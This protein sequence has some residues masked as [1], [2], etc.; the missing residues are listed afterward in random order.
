VN[1]V[2]EYRLYPTA[3][4]AAA[5]DE[6]CRLLRALYNACLQ[7]RRDA[8]QKQ[9]VAVTRTMQ[10]AQLVYIRA[11][12][13]E[14]REIS[15]QVLQGVVR[16]SD[17]AYQA[18]FRRCKAGETPGYPRFKGRGQYESFVFKQA[19]KN[20]GVRLHSAA[21]RLHIHGV[22][23][24]RIRLHRE[25]EGKPQRK[26][27]GRKKRSARR[28]KQQKL[29]AK[30]HLKVA[31]QRRDSHHKLALKLVREN[32]LIAVEDLNI[33]GLAQM[34]LSKQVHD[35]GWGQFIDILA[36]KAE[37]AGREFVKVNPRGTSQT[38]SSCGVVVPKDLSVRVH[39]CSCGYVADR[40][41]N[42]AKNIFRLGQ[43]LRDARRAA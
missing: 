29:V 30:Q 5:L 42:A 22:G 34:N 19:D 37:S 8:W 38:C 23:K 2:Y 24:V 20:N 4:Q 39:R 25:H 9:R 41:V 7:E 27:A 16:R 40:D 11:E 15:A 1:R 10:S 32:D 6:T 18:F 33:K 36:Y 13:P 26:A 3:V 17:L 35:A 43:S 14:Y 28:R 12:H 31:R 21:K